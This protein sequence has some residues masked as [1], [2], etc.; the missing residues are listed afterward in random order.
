MCFFFSPGRSGSQL[1]TLR[2]RVL[3]A[4]HGGSGDVR[5]P[6]VAQRL[7]ELGES[8]SQRPAEGGE[9]NGAAGAPARRVAPTCGK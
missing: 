5:G 7:H 1:E 4:S 8:P 6:R 9:S 2:L 3:V